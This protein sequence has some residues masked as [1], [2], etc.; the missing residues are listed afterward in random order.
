VIKLILLAGL[1]NSGEITATQPD[2][3]RIEARRRSG[4]GNK[5]RRKGGNGLR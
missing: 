1:L 2:T 5:Q 3:V 4:K